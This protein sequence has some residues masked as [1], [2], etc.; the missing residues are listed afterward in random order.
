MIAVSENEKVIRNT[1]HIDIHYHHIWNLIEKKIIEISHI[2]TDEMTVN[3][4]TK[5][6]LS[7]KFKEFIELIRV[8][9]IEL[10][11][12]ELS[13]SKS[14]NSNKNDENLVTNYYKEA[15]EE[16]ISFETEEAE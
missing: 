6:L 2:S 10:S 1:R 9:K 11:N 7:N 13:D 3:D 15:D 12:D 16:E 5:A 4:L 8:S 14:N